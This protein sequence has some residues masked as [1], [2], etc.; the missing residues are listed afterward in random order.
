MAET[1]DLG[2]DDEV[3]IRLSSYIERLRASLFFVPMLGVVVA[4][5]LSQIGIA[6]DTRIDSVSWPLGLRSTVESARSVLMTVV[7]ATI[8]FAGIAFSISLLLI[9]LGSSQYSPRVVHTL[10]RDPFNKRVM[11]LVVGTFTFCLMVLRAVRSPLEESGDPVIPNLSVSVAVLLGV[12][13]ILAIVAFISHSA[14]SMDISEILKRVSEEALTQIRSEWSLDDPGV[15]ESPDPTPAPP[16]HKIRFNESGWVRQVDRA[17]LLGCV[18]EGGVIWLETRPG[19]YAVACT[20]L[21]AVSPPPVDAGD[22]E[23]AVRASIDV[24][25]TRTMQQD[26]SFGLR[27]LVDVALKA[28]SPGINDPT[29]AQDAIFHATTVLGELLRRYPPPSEETGDGGRRLVFRHRLTHDEL[30]RLAFDEVR[31]AAASQP[32]VC[33]YLLEALALLHESLRAAG[34]YDR[35]DLISEQAQLVVQGCEAAGLLPQDLDRVH[36]AYEKWLL[37]WAGPAQPT[38]GGPTFTPVHGRSR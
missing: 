23:S 14:H 13:T 18:P 2:D 37:P 27:Q 30:V 38:P 1:A 16:T 32:T 8:T 19:R 21:C 24:G 22:I 15:H 17:A 7:G 31:P 36:A 9:Q 5:V 26:V 3:R 28:L 35:V 29:T 20:P 11:G 10:F 34:L 6:L 12:A 25:E 33:I 4:I